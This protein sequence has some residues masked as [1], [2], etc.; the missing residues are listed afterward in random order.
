MNLDQKLFFKINGLVG[1]NR[2]LDVFGRIGAKYVIF[3]IFVLA[4]IIAWELEGKYGVLGFLFVFVFMWL[5]TFVVNVIIGLI[6]KRPRPYV[7]FP[8]QAKP[9]FRPKFENWKSFPS[10]HAMTVFVIF[11]LLLFFLPTIWIWALLPLVLWVCW[12]RVFCGVHYPGDILGGMIVAFL[13]VLSL[14]II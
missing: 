8:S 3:L 13:S 7:A 10:D 12:S 2:F 9:L 14:F 6:V 5:P 11:F 4:L 1:K